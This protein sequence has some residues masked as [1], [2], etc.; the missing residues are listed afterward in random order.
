MGDRRKG[1][2]NVSGRGNKQVKQ[3]QK[4][5]EQGGVHFDR[6]YNNSGSQVTIGPDLEG[7]PMPG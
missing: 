6:I 4:N 2:E 1:G 7:T 5:E 3:R